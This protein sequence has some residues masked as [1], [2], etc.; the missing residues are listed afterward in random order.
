MG[1]AFNFGL[2]HCTYEYVAR[3]DTDDI[4]VEDRFEK[5]INFFKQ[6]PEVTIL[7]GAMREFINEPGDLFRF[8]YLPT[9]HEDIVKYSKHRC[10]FNHPTIMYKKSAL[11]NV[12]GYK[13]KEF[14]DYFLWIRL[15]HNGYISANLNDILINYRIGN[16]LISRRT[17]YTYASREYKFAA[18]AKRIGYFNQFEFLRFVILRLPLRYFPEFVLRIIYRDFLRK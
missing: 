18:L 15:L 13:L 11:V 14:E 7:G 2:M 8:K 10:P 3:M 17:G 6:H 16:N 1:I 4:A 12:G 9:K 5:Q